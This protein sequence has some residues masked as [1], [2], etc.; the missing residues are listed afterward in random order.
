MWRAWWSHPYFWPIIICVIGGWCV[1]AT[2]ANRRLEATKRREEFLSSEGKLPP[3][4]SFTGF[5]RFFLYFVGGAVLA[6]IFIR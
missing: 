3:T 5:D 4:G 2:W 6:Y 1:F